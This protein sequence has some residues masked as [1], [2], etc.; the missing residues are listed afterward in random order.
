MGLLV[1]DLDML[2]SRLYKH[3]ARGSKGAF[4]PDIPGEVDGFPCAK[5]SLQTYIRY[6]IRWHYNICA[7]ERE[8]ERER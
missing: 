5:V 1:V 7:T 3:R 2:A 8:R 4:N 6:T